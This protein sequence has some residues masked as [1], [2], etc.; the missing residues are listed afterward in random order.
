VSITL[1]TKPEVVTRTHKRRKMTQEEFNTK[2]D[3]MFGAM[4]G[5]VHLDMKT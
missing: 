2:M 5:L 4:N 3:A 1:K